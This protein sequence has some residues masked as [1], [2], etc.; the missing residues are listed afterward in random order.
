MVPPLPAVDDRAAP[1]DQ[2]TDAFAEPTDAADEGGSTGDLVTVV[3]PTYYRN[4]RLRDALTSVRDQAYQSVECVVVDGSTDRHAEPV[5]REFPGY[6]YLSQPDHQP[7]ELEGVRAVAAARDLGVAHA[8]GRYVHFLDDDDRLRPDA[9]EKQVALLAASEGVEMVYCGMQVENGPRR[10]P[11]DRVRGQILEQALRLQVAPC[12]PSTML[13]SR[14]LLERLPPM[15]TLPHDDASLMIEF[16]KRT[17]VDYVD[18]PL[19]VRGDPDDSLQSSPSSLAGRKGTLEAYDHLYERFDP[20]VRR[21]AKARV[22]LQEGVLAVGS[23]P[24]SPRAIR[25]FALANYYVPGVSPPFAAALVASLL[26]R[27]CWRLGVHLFR[28]WAGGESR[29]GIGSV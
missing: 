13:V 18:E 19:V 6:V 17:A 16:A 1:P 27:P 22:Y 8:A 24:W 5:V 29:G 20:A 3:V 11:S 4:E 25:A 21:T 15:Q 2:G 12:V 26:G 14:A 28:A 9:I 23:R 10:M 7:A